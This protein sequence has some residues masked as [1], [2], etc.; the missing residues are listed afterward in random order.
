MLGDNIDPMIDLRHMEKSECELQ[1]E[2]E[3]IK[4]E[5]SKEKKIGKRQH[6]IDGEEENEPLR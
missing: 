5:N 1:K 4:R 6:K 2:L 3:Q